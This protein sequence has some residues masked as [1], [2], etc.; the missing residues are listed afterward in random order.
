MRRR[1]TSWL[2]VV[3]GIG[4]ITLGFARNLFSV[5]PAFEEMIDDFRPALND[6]A[7]G[8]LR[9]DLQGLD[10]VAVE[11]GT[12]V[13]PAMASQLGMT[14]AEFDA[15]VA[16]EFPAV[17]GGMAIVPHAVTGFSGLVDVLDQ[18]QA[19]FR[20][21]DEIPTESLPATTVPWG[22]L[23]VGAVFVALGAAMLLTSD[24]R[25]PA[26]TAVFGLIVVVAALIFGL[27]GKSSAADDLNAAL[28]LVYTVETVDGAAATLT[29]VTDMGEQLQ[30]EMLPA[31]AAR[32]GMDGPGLEA[33]LVENFPATA[34]ALT[35]MPGM[36]ERFDGLVATFEANL[37]NY[38]TLRPVAFVPIIWALILGSA[39]AAAAGAAALRRREDDAVASLE[40]PRDR[41][42]LVSV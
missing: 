22:I 40:R 19:N 16:T 35:G 10:A 20:S 30:G 4:L 42:E 26:A 18:Q 28:E 34:S 29:V 37:D 3:V 17:A 14:P 33:F 36:I 21:A 11:F 8:A 13:A 9:A 39:A 38:E 27:P 31:L 2:V 5:G 41:S 25:A 15:Y 7:I 24:N 6:E 32:L 23:F 1:L 12:A